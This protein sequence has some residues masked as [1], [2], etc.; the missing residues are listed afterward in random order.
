MPETA[1]APSTRPGW[2]LLGE[3]TRLLLLAV[4]L[5]VLVIAGILLWQA[6]V[7]VREQSATRLG[8]AATSTAQELE[9]FLKVHLAAM[10]V[11]ADRRNA[12][13]NLADIERWNADLGRIHRHY[14]AFLTLLVTDARGVVLTSEPALPDPGRVVS[15]ADREYFQEPRRTGRGHVSNAFRGRG[16]GN[17]ALVAVSVPLRANGRFAGVL[18]ASIRIDALLPRRGGL[19]GQGLELLLLDRALTVVHAS[20]GMPHRPLDA[21]GDSAPDRALAGLARDGTGLQRLGAVLGDGGDALALAV[22]LDNGWR[23]VLLQSSEIVMEDPSILAAA[24]EQTNM[25]TN[26]QLSVLQQ[27]IAARLQN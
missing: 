24:T 27:R 19:E 21:L 25:L 2:A 3:F 23:L 10:Q 26:V 8:A 4:A 9:G 12:E 18:E 16:L 22:P 1:T 11:L 14:P 17:D 7:S 6:S 15:V 20:K 5:P 13:G